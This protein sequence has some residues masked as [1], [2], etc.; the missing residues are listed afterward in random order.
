M[1]LCTLRINVSG[2]LKKIGTII[3][4]FR[5]IRTRIIRLEEQ[6]HGDHMISAV[7]SLCTLFTT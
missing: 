1:I 2:F 6:V 7:R 4:G 5:E 3:V